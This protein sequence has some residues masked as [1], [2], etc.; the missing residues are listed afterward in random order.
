MNT[1]CLSFQ[2][3]VYPP[4]CLILSFGFSIGVTLSLYLSSEEI[5][6]ATTSSPTLSVLT[7]PTPPSTTNPP[8]VL[9]VDCVDVFTSTTPLLC[10]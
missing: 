8:V 5:H 6:D 10:T 1:S 9:E 3:K 7:I 2:S 4:I